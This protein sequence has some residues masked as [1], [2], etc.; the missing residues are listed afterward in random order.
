MLHTRSPC[1][2]EVSQVMVI[3]MMTMMVTADYDYDDCDG[4]DEDD[5]EV[6]RVHIHVHAER[7]IAHSDAERLRSLRRQNMNFRRNSKEFKE[8]TSESN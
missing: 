7:C 2:K 1:V 4:G 5:N 3:M 8:T 6:H